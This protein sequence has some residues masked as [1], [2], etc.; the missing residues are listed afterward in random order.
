M[1]RGP[2]LLDRELAN[3][4]YVIIEGFKKFIK[5]AEA[6]LTSPLPHLRKTDVSLVGVL[7]VPTHRGTCPEKP[8]SQQKRSTS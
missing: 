7:P 2:L 3:D 8:A 1:K 4:R 6:T 5:E